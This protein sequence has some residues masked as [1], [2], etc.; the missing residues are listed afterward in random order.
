MVRAQAV[1]Y[2]AYSPNEYNLKPK[3]FFILHLVHKERQCEVGSLQSGLLIMGMVSNLLLLSSTSVQ[4]IPPCCRQAY[5]TLECLL[6]LA[7][8]AVGILQVLRLQED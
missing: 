5:T 7:L 1:T 4:E 3:L 6:L 2:K 8:P